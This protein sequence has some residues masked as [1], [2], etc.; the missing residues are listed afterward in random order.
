MELILCYTYKIA[1]DR[2]GFFPFTCCAFHV[3]V[4]PEDVPENKN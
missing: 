1:P 3:I 2:L 4:P